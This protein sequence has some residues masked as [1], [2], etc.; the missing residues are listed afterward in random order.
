L[1]ADKLINRYRVVVVVEAV[2]I[3]VS[4]KLRLEEK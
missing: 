2:E 4:L 1:A 3:H